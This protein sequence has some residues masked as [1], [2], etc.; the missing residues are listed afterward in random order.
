MWEFVQGYGIWIFMAIVIAML[1]FGH[2]GG[3]G[4]GGHGSHGRHQADRRRPPRDLED[5]PDE[6][7]AGTPRNGRAHH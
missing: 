4:C 3:M 2:G 1:L 7:T 6:T 5:E